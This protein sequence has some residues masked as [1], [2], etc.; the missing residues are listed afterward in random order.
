[1][2]LNVGFQMT[3]YSPLWPLPVLRSARWRTVQ[4]E[5]WSGLVCHLAA[6]PAQRLFRFVPNQNNAEDAFLHRISSLKEKAPRPS[7]GPHGQFLVCKRGSRFFDLGQPNKSSF[8]KF[9]ILIADPNMHFFLLSGST[10][11][12]KNESF[13][14][15]L[16]RFTNCKNLLRGPENL[17]PSFC[18]R[19]DIFT[20]P[21]SFHTRLICRRDCLMH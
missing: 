5:K 14:D 20:P 19:T 12:L 4:K 13:P 3:P 16:E 1:M 15:F 10:I 11:R 8:A 9:D 18:H 2:L 6:G 21:S 17:E 7:V